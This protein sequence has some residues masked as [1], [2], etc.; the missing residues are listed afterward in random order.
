MSAVDVGEERTDFILRKFSIDVFGLVLDV[1][2][3]V[4]VLMAS[5]SIQNN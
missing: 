1:L 3:E 2:T 5:N 4:V